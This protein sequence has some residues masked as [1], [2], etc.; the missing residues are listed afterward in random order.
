MHRA[1]WYFSRIRIKD[2]L[3]YEFSLD[4]QKYR[5]EKYI[6]SE[7]TMAMCMRWHIFAPSSF[8]NNIPDII[9][10]AAVAH[11]TDSQQREDAIRDGILANGVPN[12]GQQKHMDQI[13]SFTDIPQKG[14]TG[15][16]AQYQLKLDDP[17]LSKVAGSLNFLA[18]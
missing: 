12:S 9:D 17:S 4:D 14:A 10:L 3:G 7:S 6:T 13:Y 16:L 8:K 1:M 15:A 2:I 18:P 11:P 5:L